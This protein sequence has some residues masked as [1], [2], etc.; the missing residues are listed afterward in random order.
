VIVTLDD[1]SSRDF[2]KQ[3]GK[4]TMVFLDWRVDDPSRVQGGREEKEKAYTAAYKFLVSRIDELVD[5]L[6]QTD[7]Q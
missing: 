3:P 7:G 1:E 5:E 4:S 6:A 2:P